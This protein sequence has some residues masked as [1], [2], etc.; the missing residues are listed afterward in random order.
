MLVGV[1]APCDH[2]PSGYV[3]AIVRETD[4]EYMMALGF[5]RTQAECLPQEAEETVV[6]YVSDGDKGS[7]RPGSPEWHRIAIAQ[8]EDKEAVETYV[9]EVCGADIDKRGGLETVKEKAL[10]AIIYAQEASQ[11]GES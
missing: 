1:F 8:L 6:A 9:K 5:V 7:D 10:S 11:S 2:D 3:K 4:V